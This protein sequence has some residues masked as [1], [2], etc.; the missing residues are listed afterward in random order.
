MKLHKGCLK[1][2]PK[3]APN[4]YIDADEFLKEVIQ[5]QKIG[6]CTERLGQLLLE[7]HDHILTLSRFAK[8]SPDMKEE[9]KSYSLYRILSKG[10]LSFDTNSSPQRCF[11]YFT[12]AVINNLTQACMR[13]EEYQKRYTQMPNNVIQKIQKYR[14]QMYT[15]YNYKYYLEDS[16]EESD[17]I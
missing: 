15:R 3:R 16:N 12:T 10:L 11:N 5:S 2:R 7:L 13:M 14:N 8:K 6:Q 1:M 4:N 17:E 9:A